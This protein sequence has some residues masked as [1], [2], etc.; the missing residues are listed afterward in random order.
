MA[1]LVQSGGSAFTRSV[2]AASAIPTQ[3]LRERTVDPHAAFFA[4]TLDFWTSPILN[5]QPISVIA[6]SGEAKWL[7]ALVGPLPKFS[8]LLSYGINDN[9]LKVLDQRVWVQQ[10]AVGQVLANIPEELVNSNDR[11][12]VSRTGI[13]FEEAVSTNT[14]DGKLHPGVQMK[15]PGVW[16]V[17][18]SS[19]LPPQVVTFHPL[20]MALVGSS[21]NFVVELRAEEKPVARHL[22]ALT[23]WADKVVNELHGPLY[24]FALSA[25]REPE[26]ERGALIRSIDLLF[27]KTAKSSWPRA[28]ASPLIETA[29]STGRELLGYCFD[30]V[31]RLCADNDTGRFDELALSLAATS[32]SQ[33]RGIR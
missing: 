14:L 16:K 8:Q 25:L 26:L 20:L 27:A 7:A 2:P 29:E 13:V 10:R 4:A 33:W 19:S 6:R 17:M 30:T 22:R 24:A 12:T 3:F 18:R 9:L 32:P 28:F 5:R 15:Y 1:D 23:V 31:A 21:G 11:V